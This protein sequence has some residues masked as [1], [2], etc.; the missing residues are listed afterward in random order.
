[1]FA[2]CRESTLEPGPKGTSASESFLRPF[3]EDGNL[4]LLLIS[5]SGILI[6]FGAWVL[7]TAIRSRSVAAVAAMLVL[8]VASAEAIRS[9]VRSRRRPGPVSG[10]I[11]AFWML[12]ALAAWAALHWDLF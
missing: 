11:G 9:D 1:M 8:A 4:R 12:T 10:L 6:T 3:L 7:A 2:D 5:G